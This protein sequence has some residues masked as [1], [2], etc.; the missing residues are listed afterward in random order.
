MLK[1][2]LLKNI[3]TYHSE[4]YNKLNSDEHGFII[5]I[6]E[7]DK[8]EL[9]YIHNNTYKI[10]NE[11]ISEVLIEDFNEQYKDIPF[12]S[13]KYILFNGEYIPQLGVIDI[14][15]NNI[16]ILEIFNNLNKT[17]KNIKILVK[18]LDNTFIVYETIIM[19]ITGIFTYK[20]TMC[21]YEKREN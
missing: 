19:S 20:V 3:K 9:R 14:T 15:F 10:F 18:N 12:F 16:E 1:F 13:D 5:Q 6:Y 8:A 17:N 2:N 11:H 7:N 4:F 21:I